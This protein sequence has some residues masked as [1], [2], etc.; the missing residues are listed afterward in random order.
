MQIKNE[1]IDS[2]LAK[3]KKSLDPHFEIYNNHVYRVFLL[4]QTL[5]SNQE[6]IDKYAI[7]SAFHDLGIWTD[8][9]FDYLEPSIAQALRYLTQINKKEW[10]DE[11]AL[12]I[13]MHHKRSS[14]KGPFQKTVETFRRAD[15]I[16]VTRGR[17]SFKVKKE[18]IQKTRDEYPILGFHKFLIFETLKHFLKSPLNPLPMFKK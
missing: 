10:I 8:H 16:D 6:N 15:W 3:N 13:D 5:D 7:A 11:I 2:I 1:I 9:T 18:V 12:M 4:C 14:Y 17:L